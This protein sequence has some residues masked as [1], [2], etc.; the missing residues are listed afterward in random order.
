[1][2]SI[3]TRLAKLETRS[4]ASVCSRHGCVVWY[5]DGTGTDPPSNSICPNCGLRR[6]LIV[7]RYGDPREHQG[8]AI[9][10]KPDD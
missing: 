6:L 9:P 7:V 8:F 4:T 5:D 2:S 10:P 3:K 1:M